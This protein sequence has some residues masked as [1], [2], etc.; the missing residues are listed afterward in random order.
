MQNQLNSEQNK[1]QYEQSAA[2]LLP[3]LNANASQNYSTG[4]NIDPFT[5][6]FVQS[7]VKSNNF[8]LSSNVT[9][10]Q[11]FQLQNSLQ[12]SRYNYMA[13]KYDLQ[14]NIND[15][16]LNVIT[17]YLQILYNKELLKTS[18]AQL[19]VSKTTLT[20]N[21]KLVEVGSLP[22]VNLL[23]A[24]SQVATE[25]LNVVT[26]Q[27]QLDISILSLTQ[28]LDLTSPKGFDIVDPQL[29]VESVASNNYNVDD[30][31]NY[32]LA[33]QPDIKSA[34]LKLK[35]AEKGLAA[36][37]GNRSPR[38]YVNG[39]LSTVYSDKSQFVN[40]KAGA[41]NTVPTQF[42]V[43]PSASNPNGSVFALSPIVESSG[44]TPF[45][46]QLDNNLSKS[47]G[48]GVSIPLFNNWQVQS[49][50]SRSKIS[51]LSAKITADQTKLQLNKTIQQS[52]LDANAAY[53]KYNSSVKA[54]DSQTEA[55]KYMQEK[56]NV[57][58]VTSVDYLTAKNNLNRSQATLLQAKYDFIFKT[59]VLDFYMGKPLAF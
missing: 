57:G 9:I 18:I 32:A 4:R 43:P 35:S 12:Q 14:K 20:R 27:N 54:V 26:A 7:T 2:N 15:I 28:L 25:E 46:T 53:K 21:Q 11:G 3:T 10:F 55:F 42:F 33:N 31:Y 41:F 36:A 44:V 45:G 47:V 24:E 5:N 38:V 34:E 6:Q 37:R 19:E 22:K 23:D 48:V 51:M 56:Y 49:T 50:I 30:I 40:Y 58:L 52:Y 8:S 1:T 17:A 39:S 59:K 29:T 13:S 16:S